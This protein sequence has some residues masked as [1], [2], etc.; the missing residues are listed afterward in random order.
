M[1][2]HMQ[3]HEVCRT[4]VHSKWT[5][6]NVE[7]GFDIALLQLSG[8]SRKIPVNLGKSVPTA[9]TCVTALGWGGDG[10]RFPSLFLEEVGLDTI[11]QNAC[12]TRFGSIILDSMICAGR[13]GK[14]ACEGKNWHFM[15]VHIS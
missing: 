9:E 1:C 7:A 10:N 11:E 6:N 3:V 8:T 15:Q 13:Q 2:L 4:I 12:R 14:D 5:P